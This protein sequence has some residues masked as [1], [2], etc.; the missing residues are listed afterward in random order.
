MA[1]AIGSGLSKATHD[2]GAAGVGAGLMVFLPGAVHM[3]NGAPAQAVSSFGYMLGTMLLGG[4]AGGVA[5]SVVG[6]SQC[7]SSDDSDCGFVQFGYALV[8]AALGVGTGYIVYGVYDVLE[9]ASVPAP[10]PRA[11]LGLW[12]SPVAARSQAEQA[13]FGP[14]TGAY[15]GA[16]LIF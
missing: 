4:L 13:A 14:I 6:G 16:N 1:L 8:G 12:L 2:D 3:Y 9:N 11:S 10:E 5:G 15:L 7:H